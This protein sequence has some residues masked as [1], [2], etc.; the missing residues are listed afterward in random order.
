[1]NRTT[2][3][4]DKHGLYFRAGGYIFR[5]ENDTLFTKDEPVKARCSRATQAGRIKKVCGHYYETWVNHGRYL[6]YDDEAGKTVFLDSEE[7]HN[8][9]DMADDKIKTVLA[10]ILVQVGFISSAENPNDSELIQFA[11]DYLKKLREQK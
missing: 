7:L 3:R 6:S 1:M 5:P 10:E 8:G 9:I 11:E 2:V 4:K